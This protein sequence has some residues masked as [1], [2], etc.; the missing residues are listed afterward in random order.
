MHARPLFLAV[1]LA[2]TLHVHAIGPT[3][4][5][6]DDSCDIALLPAATLLL[7]YFEVDF[8][9][10]RSET[11]LFS[12]TNVTNAERIARVTLWTDWSYPVLTFN[13]QLSA[14]EVQ[15]ISLY[16]VIAN[17]VIDGAGD[18]CGPATLPAATITRLQRAFTL[19]DGGPACHAI[20][21]VH[22]NAVG[23]ATIDVVGNCSST[24]PADAE[25]FASDIRYDNVLAGDYQQVSITRNSVQA[26]PLVHIRAIPEGGTPSSRGENPALYAN[27][28]SRTFYSR[29]QP[30]GRFNSDARQPLPA[31]FVSRWIGDGTGSAETWFRIWRQSVT[32]RDLTCSGLPRNTLHEVADVVVFDQDENAVGL[33]QEGCQILC[34]GPLYPTLPSTSQTTVRDTEIFPE[35]ANLAASAGWL[36]LNLDDDVL[37]NGAEQ[38]W[39]TTTLFSGP[40]SATMD[41]IALGNGCSQPVAKAVQ[42]FEGTAVIGPS[43]NGEPEP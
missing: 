17:G 30:Q 39:V 27:R 4:K 34:V 35:P 37:S 29:F 8:I 36:Y 7:P 12:I 14:Y 21:Y 24:M 28:F 25:Y 13:V 40:L 32:G 16:D 23:Y 9:G 43:P 10:S 2:I 41:A 31:R 38:A 42:S 5:A 11:T 18:S 3:T 22:E 33:D 26:A 6:N 1:V 19:G 15:S 20:G